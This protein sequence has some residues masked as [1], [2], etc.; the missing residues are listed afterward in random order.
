[1]SNLMKDGNSSLFDIPYHSSEFEIEGLK[2]AS[3][4]KTHCCKLC[5]ASNSCTKT[6]MPFTSCICGFH[7]F[8]WPKYF[9]V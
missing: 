6:A 9:F 2:E 3:C 7:I 5:V 8:H 4:A 1:M